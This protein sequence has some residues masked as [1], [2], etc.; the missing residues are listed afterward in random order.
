MKHKKWKNTCAHT[1]VCVNLK[2]AYVLTILKILCTYSYI[3]FPKNTRRVVCI[4]PGSSCGGRWITCSGMMCCFVG[5]VLLLHTP[6]PLMWVCCVHPL[7]MPGQGRQPG[8]QKQSSAMMEVSVGRGLVGEAVDELKVNHIDLWACGIIHSV[9]ISFPLPHP[10]GEFS[11][12]RE[13]PRIESWEK[14]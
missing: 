11:L 14:C 5:V 13:K 1:H 3:L 4:A 9:N 6:G 2:I 8:K 10:Q 7:G 12:R